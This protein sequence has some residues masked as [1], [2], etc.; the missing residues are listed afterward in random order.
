M[1]T[2]CLR[3]KDAWGRYAVARIYRG[4]FAT[5][6]QAIVSLL[7]AWNV[8]VVWIVCDD[9]VFNFKRVHTINCY[10]R[11]KFKFC[12]QRVIV[13]ILKYLYLILSLANS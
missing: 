11:K 9:A 13:D 8:T 7:K 5:Y 12:K 4:T 2:L 10:L 6:T 3:E 1:G